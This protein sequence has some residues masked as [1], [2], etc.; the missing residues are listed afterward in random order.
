[1]FNRCKNFPA[2]D[3]VEG[4]Y[5]MKTTSWAERYIVM[6]CDF[7]LYYEPKGNM[8]PRDFDKPL[9]ALPLDRVQY[10]KIKDFEERMDVSG[11]IPKT[12]FYEHCFEVPVLGSDGKERVVLL[13]FDRAETAKVWREKLKAQCKNVDAMKAKVTPELKNTID[14]LMNKNPLSHRLKE[15]P[16]S[17]GEELWITTLKGTSP[18]YLFDA[19]SSFLLQLF[20]NTYANFLFFLASSCTF[21]C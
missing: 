1:M 10:K 16:P 4:R 8:P 18:K 14:V 3:Q 9:G 12:I 6:Y 7:L 11:L 5:R 2:V 13:Q 17:G 20:C 19:F 15:A 21:V